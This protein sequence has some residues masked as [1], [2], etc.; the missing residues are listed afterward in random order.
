MN[1]ITLVDLWVV[2]TSLPRCQASETLEPAGAVRLSKLF[3]GIASR[4]SLTLEN[5][6][7]VY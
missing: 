6:V 4:K 7:L 2:D 3:L 1:I 5:C